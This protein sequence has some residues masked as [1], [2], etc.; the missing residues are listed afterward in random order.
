MSTHELKP[1]LRVQY[2]DCILQMPTQIGI[3]QIGPNHRIS[4]GFLIRPRRL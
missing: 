3:V 1:L 4:V 2:A